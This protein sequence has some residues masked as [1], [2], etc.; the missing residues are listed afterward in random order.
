MAYSVSPKGARALLDYCLP[1]RGERL[2][3]FPGTG[4]VIKD[5]GID[6][7]VNGAFISM[8]AFVCVPPLVLHDDEDASVRL[9]ANRS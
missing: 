6:C 5:T 1:L 4:V 7:A 8:Q 9:E 3:P 2:I